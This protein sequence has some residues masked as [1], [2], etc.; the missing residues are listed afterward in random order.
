M[1]KGFQM[2]A[3]C[4][5]GLLGSDGRSGSG[6]GTKMFDT[7]CFCAFHMAASWQAAS[8]LSMVNSQFERRKIRSGFSDTEI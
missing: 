8:S 5:V 4:F 6:G 7:A 3:D 1:L 2:G